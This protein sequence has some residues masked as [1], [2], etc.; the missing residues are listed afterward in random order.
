MSSSEVVQPRESD[1]I[2]P[3]GGRID[4]LIQST[5]R[6]EREAFSLFLLFVSGKLD[7]GFVFRLPY[8]LIELANVYVGFSRVEEKKWYFYGLA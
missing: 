8:R 7:L 6:G 2:P 4:L 3:L 1:V 5:S